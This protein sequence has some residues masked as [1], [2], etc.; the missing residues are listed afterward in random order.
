MIFPERFNLQNKIA[1]VTGGAGLIGEAVCHALSEAGA[2]VYTAEVDMV[3]A[4][5]L[6]ENPFPAASAFSAALAAPLLWDLSA[7]VSCA[8]RRHSPAVIPH[9]DESGLLTHQN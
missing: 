7:F 5:A 6:A 2:K 1:V 9:S 3:K 8:Q 4:E